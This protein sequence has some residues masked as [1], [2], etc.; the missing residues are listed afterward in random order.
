MA[1][2]K[3]STNERF[4]YHFDDETR[5][6][7][8][9]ATSQ[10]REN[11]RKQSG[12]GRGRVDGAKLAE[13]MLTACVLGWEGYVDESGAGVPFNADEVMALPEDVQIKLIDLIS[14]AAGEE[15]E[16]NSSAKSAAGRKS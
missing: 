1:L 7:Y 2:K 8:R 5:I 3:I 14:S 9:R 13:L 12:G 10:E 11:F 16:K 6:F 15:A 4:V